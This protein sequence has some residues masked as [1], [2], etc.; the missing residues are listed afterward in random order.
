MSPCGATSIALFLIFLYFFVFSFPAL[1]DALAGLPYRSG[2]F[3]RLF[4][5]QDYSK[6]GSIVAPL[7]ANAETLIQINAHGPLVTLVAHVRS[8]A[9]GDLPIARIILLRLK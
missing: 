8:L 4:A 3:A 5:L 6:E 2:R 1:T 7:K 9:E